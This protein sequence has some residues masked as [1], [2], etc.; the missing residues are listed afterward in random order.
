MVSVRIFALFQRL[1]RYFILFSG[2]Y[3]FF[4]IGSRLFIYVSDASA[5]SDPSSYNPLF[6]PSVLI[7]H[8]PMF[9]LLLVFA[10]FLGINRLSWSITTILYPKQNHFV[11]W[12]NVV[13]THFIELVAVY[14]MAALPHFNTGNDRFPTLLSK[15]YNL[16]AGDVQSRFVLFMV[17][18]MVLLVTV[19]GPKVVT[20]SLNSGAVDKR[21]SKK[22]D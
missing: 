20:S 8:K 14:S 9:Y 2:L 3:E 22:S 4:V 21:A 7:H 18:V 12:L 5:A 1:I 16:E 6:N 17:P 10:F 19:H 13:V 15:V 11:L